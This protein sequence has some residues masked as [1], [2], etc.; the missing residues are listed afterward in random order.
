M[1]TP[2]W[3]DDAPV[4]SVNHRA[5]ERETQTLMQ[6]IDQAV[7]LREVGQRLDL[8]KCEI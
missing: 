4:I 6:M 8:A 3:H 5:I 2:G 1:K 7:K